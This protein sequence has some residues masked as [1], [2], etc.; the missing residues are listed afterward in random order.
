MTNRP[1]NRYPKREEHPFTRPG[2]LPGLIGMLALLIG[3]GA[4]DQDWWLVIL[5]VVSIFA[6]I[7]LVFAF[8][9]RHWW[10][11]PILAGIAV[12]WNPA[13]PIYLPT[14]ELWLAA[15]IVGAVLM[16]ASGFLIKVPNPNYQQNSRNKKSR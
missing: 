16:M 4:L 15:H 2:L 11:W 5:F 8:Q 7:N 13:W 10:W 12:L 6:L 14:Y 9:A 1:V 3:I